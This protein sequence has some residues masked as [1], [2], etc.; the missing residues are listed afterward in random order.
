MK[1][2]TTINFRCSSELKRKLEVLQFA[3]RKKDISSL[4]IEICSNAIE[5]NSELIQAIETARQS[6]PLKGAAQM[7]ADVGVDTN[8]QN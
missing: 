3:T 2:T 7:K 4:L 8:A 1:T 5:E 6:L